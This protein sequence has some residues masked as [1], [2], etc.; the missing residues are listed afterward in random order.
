MVD[1][2]KRKYSQ[3]HIEGVTLKERV[4][5]VLDRHSLLKPK[6]ICDILHI[7]YY[8]YGDTVRSYKYKWR[9]REQK[10]R[11]G[12]TSLSTKNVRFFGYC[13]DSIT[14]DNFQ[15]PTFS[16][17]ASN[18][19]CKPLLYARNIRGSNVWFKTKA[20]NGMIVFKCGIGRIEW[21]PSTGRVLCWVKKPATAGKCKQLLAEG[22]YKT[23]FVADV[24][25]FDK[26][27]D[28]FR[29]LGL[30]LVLDTGER[31]PYAKISMLKEQTGVVVVMGDRSHP[32]GL[33]MH[34]TLPRWRQQQEQLN[35]LTVSA[36]ESTN[37]I[38]EN[39]TRLM[40]EK[41]AGPSKL[42]GPKMDKE[43][44]KFTV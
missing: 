9:K 28:S 36:L 2:K 13:L 15:T 10:I 43:P 7:N 39:F 24:L 41:L 22:F 14:V 1:D 35:A 18:N 19:M 6:E 37:K 40:N 5:V 34:I 42:E 30:D 32:T 4:F 8:K 16:Q 27:A 29:L 26:W 21:F 12:L 33:E 25:V 20:K 11:R 44:N 23:G 17:F 3:I 38:I 31:L